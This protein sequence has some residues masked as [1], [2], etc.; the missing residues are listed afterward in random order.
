MT[1]IRLAEAL[2]LT[3]GSVDGPP[4]ERRLAIVGKGERARTIPVHPE[5][6]RVIG[7]Y[8]ASRAE[9]YP[10]HDL[11]HPATPLFVS[12]RGERLTPRQVQYLVERLYV[13]A[14][15]RA[16]VPAGALV[17]ALRHTFAT[18]ALEGGASV[19]E[20]SQLLGHSSLDTTRRYRGGDGQRAEGCDQGAPGAAGVEEA[21]GL[22]RGA[23]A[24]PLPSPAGLRPS[25]PPCGG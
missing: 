16:Q 20:V 15:I 18:S 11:G 2:S 3:V 19:L 24:P 9:R 21:S 5:L 4:G 8:L 13:R 25:A 22:T 23:V 14:G 1:G 6:E 12:A 7:A 10:A 17:H